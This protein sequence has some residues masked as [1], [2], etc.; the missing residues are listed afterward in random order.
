MPSGFLPG[1]ADYTLEAGGAGAIR[2]VKL[3]L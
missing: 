1:S 2:G 3:V